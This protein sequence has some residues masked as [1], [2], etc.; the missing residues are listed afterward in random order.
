MRGV[1]CCFVESQAF[2]RGIPVPPACRCGCAILRFRQVAWQISCSKSPVRSDP[3]ASRRT[4]YTRSRWDAWESTSDIAFSFLEARS[5]VDHC[6]GQKRSRTQFFEVFVNKHKSSRPGR[7]PTG[8]QLL[9]RAPLSRYPINRA[10]V[11]LI[12]T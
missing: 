4:Q 7:R 9:F 1:S 10:L 8:W 2:W 12:E 5:I 6:C 11:G 3:S